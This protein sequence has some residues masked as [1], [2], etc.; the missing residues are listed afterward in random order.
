MTFPHE[1]AA[2]MLVEQLYRASELQRGSG[3]HKA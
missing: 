2:V 1:L 3:Y